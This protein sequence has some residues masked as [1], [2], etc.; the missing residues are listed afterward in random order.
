MDTEAPTELREL[1][2]QTYTMKR[3]DLA[4]MEEAEQL[5]HYLGNLSADTRA[6]FYDLLQCL[7]CNDALS[8]EEVDAWLENY[9]AT[10][11]VPTEKGDRPTNR[12]DV[13]SEVIRELVEWWVASGRPVTKT[14]AH[15]NV[16]GKGDSDVIRFLCREYLE[17]TD[18][19]LKNSMALTE[20]KKLG[21]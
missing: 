16:S 7:A 3:E 9:K 12:K 19:E 4:M 1:L 11:W 14:L 6:M 20:L 5:R 2:R 21:Y 8:H 15:Q 13:R 18:K 17:V 10:Y